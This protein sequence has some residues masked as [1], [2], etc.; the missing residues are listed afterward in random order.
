ML[1]NAIKRLLVME[2]VSRN[3]TNQNVFMIL[4]TVEER[5]VRKVQVINAYG[6]GWEMGFVI[7]HVIQNNV[8]LTWEI[9]KKKM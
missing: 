3:V 1:N 2:N 8:D 9:V 4:E 6:V 7:K 5:I